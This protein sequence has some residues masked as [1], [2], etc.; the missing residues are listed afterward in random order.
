MILICES[1]VKTKIYPDLF[2]LFDQYQKEHKRYV[3]TQI[4]LSKCDFSEDKLI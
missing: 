1:L 2:N 4:P 3:L